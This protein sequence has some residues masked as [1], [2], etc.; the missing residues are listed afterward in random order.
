MSASMEA[1]EFTR[2]CSKCGVQYPP[3]K[4]KCDVC[5]GLV[6]SISNNPAVS[7]DVKNMLPKFL[8]IGQA[9]SPNPAKID[10]AEPIMINPI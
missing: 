4:Q 9:A 2:V 1:A 3:R 7:Y 10:T 8:D 5:S 6:V